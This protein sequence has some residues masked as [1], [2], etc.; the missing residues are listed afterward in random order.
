MPTLVVDQVLSGTALGLSFGLADLLVLDIGGRRVL[1]ALSRTEATL[2][3]VTV[4]SDGTL[5]FDASLSLSGSFVAG[6]EPLLGVVSGATALVLAGLTASSGQTIAL[7]SDGSLGLQGSLAGLE[8]LVSPTGLVAGS[9]PAMVT[10]RHGTGGLDLLTDTGSGLAFRASLADGPDRY[11]GDVSASVA[12]TLE[13]TSYL[14]STSATEDG[15]NLVEVTPTALIQRDAF[16]VAEGL[17]VNT[18]V[19]IGVVQ[20][21]GETQLVTGSFDTSSISVVQVATGGQMQ[22][23]DHILDSPDTRFQGLSALDTLVHGDFAFVAAGGSDGG[24]SLFTVLPGGRLV[25]LDSIADDTSTTLYRVSSIELVATGARLDLL[26]SSAWEAGI[27]RISYDLS[28]LGAVLVAAQQGESLTGTVGDDQIIGSGMGDTLIGGAGHD[29]LTDGAGQDMLA[30]GGGADLFALHPDGQQDTIT[31]Y[32]R[33][34]DRLDLSAWDFLYDVS[35]LT[36]VPTG[37][38]AVLSHGSETLVLTSSD[39][40]PLTVGDFSNATILNVDRP[41]L[42]PIAQVLQGG[43]GAD[44]LNGAWGN[45]TIS[46]AGGD[47]ELTG[48]GGDD[49]IFGGDGVDILDGGAGSDTLTGDA[50]ADTLVGGAGDDRLTGGIGDDVIHGDEYDWTGG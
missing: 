37:S 26:V 10:G 9:V 28:A 3:E 29:T 43:P 5:S 11:L 15:V 32:D 39:G 48:Q 19:E 42:L 20:R 7:A 13:G 21:L 23:S 30:G 6:S 34:A 50:G 45:D 33:A 17:P 25:H 22:L 36:I 18:P 14:A 40:N 1:Y 8:L 16:G 4:A 35:Q 31:D 41:P 2:V 27:T 24:V 46:G 47:D 49:V 38:G 12:F 44:T